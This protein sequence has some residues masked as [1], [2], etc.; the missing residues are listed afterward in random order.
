M[1]VEVK[2]IE[3]GG[4]TASL[5]ASEAVFGREF[6]ET[7]VH[8]VVVAYLAAG[9]AG[10]KAQK[11]RADVSGGGAKPWRQKGGGRARAGTT[12]GPLWRTGGVTF[13][14]SPRN[15]KQKVNRKVYRGAIRSILSELLRQDRL[16]VSDDVLVQA[17]KTKDLLHKLASFPEGSKLIVTDAIDNNLFLAARNLPRVQVC[18]SQ[19][20]SPAA[21]VGCEQVVVTKAAFKRLEESLA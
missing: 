12:R 14:A 13:A 15:Y 16:V 8:Q 21:L 17:P 19:N 7:M 18:T 4:K 9:R 5:Q 1:S 3:N 20:L 10:T 2:V 11:S 6:N